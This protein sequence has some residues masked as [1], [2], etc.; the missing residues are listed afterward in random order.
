MSY[1]GAFDPRVF[2]WAQA[3]VSLAEVNEFDAFTV[4]RWQ[5]GG[6]HVFRFEIS[7]LLG[8]SAIYIDT[9]IC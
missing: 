6:L 4:I 3:G 9:M 7:Y 5:H 2:V 8:F 1:C